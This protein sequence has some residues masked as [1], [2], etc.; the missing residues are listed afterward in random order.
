RSP[1][2]SVTVLAHNHEKYIGGAIDSVLRQTFADLEV[3]VVDD[4]STD[5]TAQVIGSF[6]DPRLISIRQ[7]NQGP[8]AAANRA[9]R[10]CRGRYIALMSGDDVC[11]PERVERQL[12]EYRRGD[13]RLLFSAVELIGENGSPPARPSYCDGVFDCRPRTRTEIIH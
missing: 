8:S 6:R 7:D 9:L 1:L 11:H 4:G 10:S 5:G 3:V 12:E 13:R 2:V